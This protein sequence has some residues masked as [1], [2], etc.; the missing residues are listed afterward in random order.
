M[1]RKS[2]K[3]MVGLFT[4]VGI[5]MIVVAIIW[6]GATKYFEKGTMYVT[7][8]DESVTGLQKDSAVKY[9]GVEVGRVASMG[10]APDNKLVAVVMKITNLR[11]DL[12]KVAVAQL[13]FAGITGM[14]FVELDRRKTG[15]ADLSPKLSF[16]AEYPVIPSRPSEMQ[17][18]LKG[19]N[20]VVEKFNQLDIQGVLA[21]FKSTAAEMER[22][23]KGKR[24]EAIMANM[25][26]ASGHVKE[27]TGHVNKLL[28]SGQVNDILAGSNTVLKEMQATVAG[29]R[30]EIADLNLPGTVSKARAIE[31]QLGATVENLRRT[32]EGLEEFV[33]RINERP[34]D[35][36]FG[37]PPKGRWNETH[38]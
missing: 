18:M 6:V 13:K 12:S 34:S 36:L 15:D 9:R 7:Y 23:L 37:Q 38:K 24:M 4:T 8:F 1:A 14:M 33:R 27:I 21:Q 17:S 16:P 3:F 25:D 32:T 30:K 31:T 10:L 11:D 26:T 29:L 22:F 20:D 19:V 2:S 5:V 28:A 35:L